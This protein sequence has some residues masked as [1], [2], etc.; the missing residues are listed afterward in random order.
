[1]SQGI[2]TQDSVTRICVKCNQEK[3]TGHFVGGRT[4]CRQCKNAETSERYYSD[5]ETMQRKKRIAKTNYRTNREHKL[6][7]AKEY[8]SKNR[9]AVNAK[10]RDDYRNRGRNNWLQKEYGISEDEFENLLK[11]QNGRCAICG[12]DSPGGSRK[13][14]NVDHDH[15][16]GNVRGLLCWNCNSA[17][18]LLKDDCN[19]I[20]A[21]ARHVGLP[22]TK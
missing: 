5:A 4:K 13:M 10:K 7:Y 15:K 9:D 22:P 17:I 8:L 18:G 19:I 2:K 14:W 12:T 3:S 16:S 6:S 1:M 21:A 11:S 20:M